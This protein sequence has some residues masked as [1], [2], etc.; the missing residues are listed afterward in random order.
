MLQPIW[1]LAA[2]ALAAVQATPSVESLAWLEGRWR[3]E[4]SGAGKQV[5]MVEEVWTDSAA[6]AMFGINRTVRG[7][8]TIAFEY[9]RI[10]GEDGRPVFIAQPN[11]APPARFPMVGHARN[12]IVF[13]NP[14]HD[15]P[16]RIIYRRSGNVLTG[17]ISLADGSKPM[18][19]TF[20]LQRPR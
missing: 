9:M 8:K 11:G 15:Y 18:S 20:R 10:V 2:A 17:T 14:A 5:E 1:D 19:W 16:Q 3:A 13:A 7:R 6:G 12:Q 4:D